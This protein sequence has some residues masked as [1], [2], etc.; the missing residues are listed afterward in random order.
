MRPDGSIVTKSA[1]VLFLVR[2]SSKPLTRVFHRHLVRL[3]ISNMSNDVPMLA[4]YQQ[5]PEHLNGRQPPPA[6]MNGNHSSKTE[7]YSMSEG[8]DVPLVR[9]ALTHFF[10]SNMG[11]VLIQPCPVPNHCHVVVVCT[12]PQAQETSLRRVV[13]QRRR[14]AA[15]RFTREEKTHCQREEGTDRCR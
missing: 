14:Q 7:D 1:L 13:Q 3:I 15:R 10:F 2:R 9:S 5:A 4:D 6:A 8:D 11:L 12:H